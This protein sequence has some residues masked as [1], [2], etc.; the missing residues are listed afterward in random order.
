MSKWVPYQWRYFWKNLPY[1]FWY[2]PK[3]L[4]QR[5]FRGWSDDEL[6]SLDYTLG[7]IISKYLKLFKAL[8]R[9][10]YPIGLNSKFI[11]DDSTIDEQAKEFEGKWEQIL[12]DMIYGIDYLTRHDDRETD[13]LNSM[14]I[15]FVKDPG[16]KNI[17][18]DRVEG[19]WDE[20]IKKVERIMKM[21][22]RRHIFL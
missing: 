8:N 12:D 16:S 13:L 14:G 4:L 7:K 22:R 2:E 9:M 3:Y 11:P 19:P 17:L 20:Y 18:Y 5:I 1:M 15:K 21:P 10:G 6:W